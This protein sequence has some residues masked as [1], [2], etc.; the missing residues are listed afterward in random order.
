MKIAKNRVQGAKDSRV[1]VYGGVD[2]PSP[3]LPGLGIGSGWGDRRMAGAGSALGTGKNKTGT[4]T[5]LT[6]PAG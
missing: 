3:G 1:Q 4:G 2:P 5:F 6:G